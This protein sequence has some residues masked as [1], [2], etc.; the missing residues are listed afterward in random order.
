MTV[1]LVSRFPVDDRALSAL[2][3]RAFGVDG[4]VE[5]WADRLR[6][7]AL[8]WVGAFDGGRLVGFVQVAWDGGRHAFLLDTAVDPDRQHRGLGTRLV[9]AAVA[10]ARAAG[11]DWLHVDFEP[12]LERFYRDG[13]GFQPTAG[14]LIRL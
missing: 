1:E 4:P 2:H 11:C 12:R 5:P 13:C 8:T 14:G 9:R 3:A 7:H 10:E 6:R